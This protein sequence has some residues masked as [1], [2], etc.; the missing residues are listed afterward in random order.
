MISS[1]IKS[2]W[3]SFSAPA[4]RAPG[5]LL[6]P[7]ES[8]FH[9]CLQRCF[10]L[11]SPIS[12]THADSQLGLLQWS[13]STR[14]SIT[15]FFPPRA[16]L[17][18]WIIENPGAAAQTQVMVCDEWLWR[19]TRDAAPRVISTI[20]LAGNT[21]PDVLIYVCGMKSVPSEV[22]EIHP[23]H[24]SL[25]SSVPSIILFP[26]R[27]CFDLFFPPILPS[28]CCTLSLTHLIDDILCVPVCI[29]A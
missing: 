8:R 5:R 6:I 22:Q 15:H 18:S 2:C 14:N 3:K 24:P 11:T 19:L 1:D 12:N 21:C 26:V 25:P 20:V 13:N 17:Q 4:A 9:V 23:A 10:N 27:L 7:P 16:N 28:A 29:Q